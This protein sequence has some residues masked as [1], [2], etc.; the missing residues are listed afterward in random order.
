M[1]DL[2][3]R[4]QPIRLLTFDAGLF[5]RAANSAVIAHRAGAGLGSGRQEAFFDGT[6]YGFEYAAEAGA[7]FVVEGDVDIR[8]IAAL[9]TE[10]EPAGLNRLAE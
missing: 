1:T 7:R 3:Q 5:V 4:V 8:E 6:V 10:K 2:D 9:R